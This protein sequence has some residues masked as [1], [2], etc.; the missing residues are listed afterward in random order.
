MT[1]VPKY[2]VGVVLRCVYLDMDDGPNYLTSLN[3]LYPIVDIHSGAYWAI[4]DDGQKRAVQFDNVDKY[5]ECVKT[6][7]RE[8][9]KKICSRLGQ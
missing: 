5:F 6:T 9:L 7:R 1:P 2:K 3:R 8:K 4:A